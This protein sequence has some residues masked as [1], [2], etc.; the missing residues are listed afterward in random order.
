MI[1]VSRLSKEYRDR[2]RGPFR[3][4]DDV[5]FQCN[6]GEIVG[7]LGPNGAGK[8]TTL[9][10]LSTAIKP[11]GGTATVMGRNVLT[12]A[13]AIRSSIGFLSASTGLY[14]RLSARETLR[15]FGDL[16]GVSRAD[17]A[18]RT[19]EL[20]DLFGMN[21]FLDRRC[22]K[23]STG[24][25]QKVNI[26]RTVLH[27]PPVMIFDEPTSGLDV[28]TS[29]TIV[30]FIRRCRE[31]QKTVLFSTHIMSEVEKLCDRVAIIHKGRLYFQGTVPELQEKA[32]GNLEDAFIDLIGEV[33]E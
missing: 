2:K 7:L 23:L 20:A 22:D 9:R 16:F 30:Q 5:T 8:T 29:R 33:S 17:I 11:T 10:M 28:L 4:V 24:M 1:D 27:D 26:A 6:P 13:A 21:E 12:D 25:K 31:E 3:A 15:Y 14:G 19:K 18:R 32:G